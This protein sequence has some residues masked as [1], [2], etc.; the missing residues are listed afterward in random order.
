MGVMKTD[1][2]TVVKVKL[3]HLKVIF[4]ALIIFSIAL[5]VRY[6]GLNFAF[7]LLTHPDEGIIMNRL[8]GMSVNHSL[9]PLSYPYPA[10]P[11]YY[12]KFIV[13]NALSK[14]R[15]GVNYGL[16]YWNDPHFFYTAS[17][18]MTA[19]HGALLPVVAW[20]IGRKFKQSNFSWVAAV[21]FTFYPVFVLHSHYVT[22]DIP[23]TLFVMLVLLFCLNYLSTKRNDWLILASVMVA[24]S[25]L[26]KYPGILSVGIVWTSVAIRAFSR[27]EQNS[28][29][30]WRFFFKN[31]AW[32]LGLTILAFFLIA[33]QLFLNF[34]TTLNNLVREARPTHLGA[35]GL[36]WG[37]NLL[38][39]LK[40]FYSNSGLIIS[41]LAGVGL[42]AVILMKDPTY[43]LLFFGGGYWVALSILHLHHIRWSLPMMTTPLF[44]AAIGISYL[45]QKT[46]K[47]LPARM[48]LIVIVLAGIVPFAL[49]GMVTSIMLTWS[50]T[51]NEALD[52]LEENDITTENTFSDGYTPFNPANKNRD[53]FKF[54][55]FNPGE[56][57]YIV[58][59]SLMFDR[60]AAEPD[61]Y[62][63]QNAFYANVRSNLE[64]IKEFH[65][66][67]EPNLV[68][69]QLKVILEY[70]NSQFRNSKPLFFSGPTLEIYKLQE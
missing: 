31:T 12:S 3:S 23:L 69:D 54:D 60:Y 57:E 45:W 11:S 37:G 58:L 63:A 41:A 66:D 32:S 24:I 70:L 28:L 44:L 42:T 35:D 67:P 34:S 33:P 22:V 51:R 49:K 26:E 27:N 65:P 16:G 56:K 29:P 53:F 6:V 17:R 25:G 39:Y 1:D 5:V 15:F 43:L 18:L 4:F 62:V 59:S 2:Q 50:D 52:F 64:L 61:R 46:V 68:V 7:P 55:I 21:L 48:A 10:F 13:L 40:N 20:F 14:L 8:K 47:R 38:F 19:V 30:G 9:D 36:G